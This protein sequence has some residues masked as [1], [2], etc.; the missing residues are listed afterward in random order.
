MGAWIIRPRPRPHATYRLFCFPWA[1]GGASA[2]AAWGDLLPQ[3]VELCA[4]QPP[5]RE[6]RLQERPFV[7]L[8]PLVSAIADEIARQATVPFALF[9]HSMGGLIAFELA[10]RFTAAGLVPQHLFV[11][12]CGAP[13]FRRLRAPLHQLDDPALLRALRRFDGI[14]AWA[15]DEPELLEVIMPVLRAD[16]EL[17]ETYNYTTGDP[18]P[19]G[20]TAFGGTEDRAVL[21]L[22]IAGWERHTASEFVLRLLSGSHFFITTQRALILEVI[23]DVLTGPR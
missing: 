10:R 15:L 12:G 22:E 6:N 1:G 3:H 19:C 20:I 18:L 4:V 8:A 14:P 21:P 17:F 23:G 16:L 9:G 2:Y 11:T 5:G 13:H 7:R